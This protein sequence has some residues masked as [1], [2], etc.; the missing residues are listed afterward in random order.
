MVN[1]LGWGLGY[2]RITVILVKIYPPPTWTHWAPSAFGM[3]GFMLFIFDV[4]VWREYY[5][6]ASSGILDGF[7]PQE[8]LCP[9]RWTWWRCRHGW[10]RACHLHLGFCS[11]SFGYCR[12]IPPTK[13]V[14]K[15]GLSE[16]S[17]WTVLRN[18]KG[19]HF[20]DCRVLGS[21]FAPQPSEYFFLLHHVLKSCGRFSV[22]LNKTPQKSW[23]SS[24]CSPG[25][26]SNSPFCCCFFESSKERKNQRFSPVQKN[27]PLCSILMK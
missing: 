22:F 25:V 12:W 2:P 6:Q 26:H 20:R 19:F 13:S 15:T 10:F 27:L 1:T 24:G 11:P 21:L 16:A 3:Y 4:L 17:S 18:P 5:P 9:T 8:I 14:P 7:C 23:S